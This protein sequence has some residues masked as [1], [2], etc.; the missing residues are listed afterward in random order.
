MSWRNNKTNRQTTATTELKKKKTE[1]KRVKGGPPRESQTERLLDID[2]NDSTRDHLQLDL[3]LDWQFG[4]LQRERAYLPAPCQFLY[5]FIYF[6]RGQKKEEEEKKRT[7]DWDK[8]E[9]G[10]ENYFA[11]E[12]LEWNMIML[13][14]SFFSTWLGM[15]LT[16]VIQN[17]RKKKKKERKRETPVVIC[18]LS[19]AIICPAAAQQ[20]L[21]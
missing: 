11:S 9:I 19:G 20:T 18:F 17:T 12:G 15:Q 4:R 7:K 13:M 5:L 6:R 10:D 14:C 3:C 2:A 16:I 21:R 8:I 1:E